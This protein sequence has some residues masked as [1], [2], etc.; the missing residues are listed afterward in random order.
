MSQN[1]GKKARYGVLSDGM[2]FYLIAVILFNKECGAM[3][4]YLLEIEVYELDQ[5]GTGS[6]YQSRGLAVSVSS[7]KQLLFIQSQYAQLWN[8]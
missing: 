3:V 5:S 7:E 6:A 1:G 4:A 2:N 8:V